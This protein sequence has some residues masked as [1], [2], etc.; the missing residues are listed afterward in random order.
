MRLADEYTRKSALS[1]FARAAMKFGKTWDQF[2]KSQD[3]TEAEAREWQNRNLRA[4]RAGYASEQYNMGIIC[5]YGFGVEKTWT[6]PGNG[7][8]RQP[9]RTMHKPK[10]H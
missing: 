9:P 8:K 5:L 2:C 4:A 7:W 10:R 3:F 1:G 6:P